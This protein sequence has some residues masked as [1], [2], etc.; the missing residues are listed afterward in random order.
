M[1]IV[2]LAAMMFPLETQ[3]SLRAPWF[4]AILVSRILNC[5]QIEKEP[6]YVTHICS[7]SRYELPEI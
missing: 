4:A 1:E 6:F 5:T 3:Y 2:F 7:G